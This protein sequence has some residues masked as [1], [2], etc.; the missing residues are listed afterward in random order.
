MAEQ[1]I[2]IRERIENMRIKFEE[3][4]K[5]DVYD[6]SR[7]QKKV[8]NEEKKEKLTVVC[9]KKDYIKVPAEFKSKI[10]PVNLHLK[11]EKKKEFEKKV[12]ECLLTN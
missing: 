3:D 4:H 10:Q 8:V 9:T 11:I 12:L 2:D 1:I 5:S 6:A 7:N